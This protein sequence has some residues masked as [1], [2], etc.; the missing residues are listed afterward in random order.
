VD[1]LKVGEISKP[2]I[3]SSQ[4]GLQT[5]KILYLKSKT[6]AHKANL[7]QDFPKIKDMAYGD[8]INRSVSEWFERRRK[9]TYVKIDPEYSSCP[10]LKTWL[11]PV[12]TAQK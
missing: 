1:T 5:Y 12:T 8:K 9:D 2:Q 10:Q 4:A 3:F 6:D 11:T 7:E